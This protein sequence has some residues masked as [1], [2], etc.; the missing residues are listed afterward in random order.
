MTG[1]AIQHLSGVCE[2]GLYGPRTPLTKVKSERG[3]WRK[4]RFS[5][6]KRDYPGLPKSAL[7]KSLDALPKG[8]PAPGDWFPWLKL[9]CAADGP[10]E[11]LYQKLDD[12][13]FTAPRFV[14]G[15]RP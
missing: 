5:G 12:T 11:D 2:R 8:G 14:P 15:H 13:R 10:V 6:T 1:N 3:R 4:S 7:S 9:K